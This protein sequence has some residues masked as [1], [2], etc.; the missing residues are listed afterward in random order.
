MNADNEKKLLEVIEELIA[1]G[2]GV[3]I[4]GDFSD[5]QKRLRKKISEIKGDIK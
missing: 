2:Y 5:K 4:S 1:D 3:C